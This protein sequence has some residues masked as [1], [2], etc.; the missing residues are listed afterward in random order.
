MKRDLNTGGDRPM[1]LPSADA[2]AEKERALALTLD[3]ML[4]GI[5]SVDAA[6]V[7]R[8]FN[9]RVLELLDLPA[10]LFSTGSRFEDIL[11]FQDAR[12]DF[13][14]AEPSG[15]PDRQA[16]DVSPNNYVRQTR[17]GKYMEV[18]TVPVP[19]GGFVR[20]YVDVTPYIL[21]QQALRD[22]EHEL[23]TM[24][25]GFPGAMLVSD[26]QLNYVYLND[27]AAAWTGRPRDELIGTSALPYVPA[28][29]AAEI[30]EF[31]RSAATGAQ[32]TVESAYAGTPTRPRR[33]LQV[34]QVMGGE[35]RDG[36]RK[37]Y[38]FAVDI[39]ARKE[40]EEAL[41]AAKEQAERANRAKSDFLRNISH[42]LRTPMNAIAG[43]G[44]LLLSD[45]DAPLSDRQRLHIGE[46]RHGA[47]HLLALINELLD[48]S[49]A[50][51]GKLK[52]TPATVPIRSVIDECLAL[53]RPLADSARIR[54]DA[55]DAHAPELHARADR[56]R[57]VQV[58]LN[59]VSNA[60]KYN[61]AHGTVR[62]R[63]ARTAGEVQIEVSDDGP[64]LSVAQQAR[65]FE[66]FERLDA[67]KTTIEGAGLGLAL[68][69]VLVRAMG[70]S[71]AID[72]EIG[73]GSTFRISL[74]AADAW[75]AN[76]PAPLL[77]QSTSD[78]PRKRK[79]LYLEDNPVN[80]LLMEAMLERLPPEHA[81]TMITADRPEL[82]LSMA[83]S[84]APDQILLDIQ[85]PG[86][87]GFEVLRRLRLDPACRHLPVI[88]VSANTL[89]GDTMIALAAG[90]D[91][92]LGKP[93][94]MHDL[95]SAVIGALARPEAV[96]TGRHGV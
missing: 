59:L 31:M 79:V 86:I 88:S 61:S 6:G 64:G 78:T 96:E 82:G 92:A 45:Q 49:M 10:E 70:G 76:G 2:L 69:N 91:A 20:T 75:R 68:S 19:D 14:A 16:F 89:A 34:T 27:R 93:F 42:E 62:I 4:H 87:D 55:V 15:S 53:L 26:D 21:T 83:V 17:A 32:Q 46:I 7:V 1:P 33:W 81:L 23:R 95:H 13:A 37:C 57:L 22:S 9:K 8:L 60:I 47:R 30:L 84:E 54:L 36:R 41:I 38:V 52:V 11:H 51:Q 65:L 85:L 58:L 74:P 24:L 71:I 29:R 12:G 35:S 77:V 80:V 63:G 18:R 56:T 94:E 39:T 28:R 66:A 25:D 48:L 43:F 44:E 50:E 40:A 90:F 72:S 3:S 67:G 73:R 5:I